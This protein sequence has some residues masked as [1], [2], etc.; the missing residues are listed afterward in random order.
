MRKLALLALTLTA[1]ASS[2]RAQGGLSPA[3]IDAFALKSAGRYT[4]A[5][6]AFLDLAEREVDD[7]TALTAARAVVHVAVARLLAERIGAVDV[8]A[9]LEALA[10]RSGQ[11]AT[12][13]ALR[14]AAMRLCAGAGD[15][16]A[17]V[18]AQRALGYLTRFWTC[19][20]F[21]NER[22]QGFAQAYP[23]ETGFDVAGSYDGKKRPVAW[24]ALPVT[25]PPEGIVDLGAL[26]RPD[27]Q[28]LV[29]A[30]TALVAERDDDAMLLLGTDGSYRV[31]LN[32]E[33]VAARDVRRVRRADQD[34]VALRLRRGPNLLLLKLCAQDGPLRFSARLR[35]ARGQPIPQ[36]AE[37]D[38][39]SDLAAAA[40][41]AAAERPAPKLARRAVEV[42]TES[43]RGGDAAD[44]FR[45][46]TLLALRQPDDPNDRRDR[47]LAEAAVAA[48]PDFTPAR[49]L[50]A[51][52]R[53]QTGRAEEKD[54]NQRR[55]DYEEILARDPRHAEAMRSLAEMDLEDVGAA[56]RAEALCRRALEV[57][58]EFAAARLLLARAL[59]AQDL[60][61][62]ADDEVLAAAEPGAEGRR[63]PEAMR[64]ALEV[65][66]RT[67]DPRRAEALARGLV[68]TDVD[69]A[70][71]EELARALL[72][73]G[74]REEALSLLRR[75]EAMF[76]FDPRPR[77]LLARAMEA[78]SDREGAA[79]VLLGWLDVCPEDD[80]VLV[81]LARLAGLLGETE[82]E[83]ELLRAA[84]DLNPN[85]KSEVRLLEFLEADEVPFHQAYERDADATIA[86]VGAPPADAEAANDSHHWILRQEV[87]RA[88]RNGTRSVY[89]HEIV[90]VLS[91]RAIRRFST[92][93]V[94]HDYREERARILSARV[95]KPDGRELRPRLRGP[96]AQLPP[97]EVGDIVDVRARIDD[98]APTIFGDYFGLVHP[99]V[100]RD[101][102][103]VA[104]SELVL[105]LDPGRDYEYQQANGA[106][107]PES[108]TEDSGVLVR[109]WV[110]RDLA[111]ADA[112]ERAPGWKETAPLVRVTTYRSWDAFAAWW[113]NL[114]RRQSDVSPEMRQ[115]VEQL[116][117][118]AGTDAEKIAAIYAFVT[119]EVRY[120][121]WEF[122]V[123]GYK[124]YNTSV[125]FERRHGD[126]K[127]KSLLLNA[128]LGIAGIEAWPVLI[129]AERARDTDDLS[130]AMVEH[131]NHCI[132]FVPAHGDRP[133]MFLDGTA[134]WHTTDTIPE[135]DQGA[136]V[137]VVRGP[138]GEL[139]DVPWVDATLNV[140]D[141]T[142]RV[143]LDPDGS[144][145]A[146]LV[147]T[148]GRN[149]AVPFREFLANEPARREENVERLLSRSFGGVKV[150]ELDAGQPED[151]TR[152]V[153]LDV[154]FEGEDLAA[155]QGAGLALKPVFDTSPL[156][157]FTPAATRERPLLLG[158]PES[159][160]RIVRY[161]LPDGWAPT[162][163]PAPVELDARF[164]RYALRWSFDDG[165]L[166]VERTRSIALPRIEAAEYPDFREFAG[167]ADAADARTVVVRPE[168]R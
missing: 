57:S 108:T 53:V 56:A 163:L 150:D 54:E 51:F 11:P 95:V 18:E 5:L 129:W 71:I 48:M 100:A 121:A 120:K 19:G 22:G 99:F 29:Y 81:E 139:R 9:R 82:R 34:V 117:A 88:Y 15:L 69:A 2:A 60:Q 113:W 162:D 166:T 3:E 12:R 62:L 89:R 143:A 16:P 92:W 148:P 33:E 122:G 160:H 79:A 21:D 98:V 47:G 142:I 66:R 46:A 105:L 44:A 67:P 59:A 36:V 76:P 8:R 31:F 17:V 38:D 39:P 152:P 35:D 40:R 104:I 37:S 91:D 138:S 145:R 61:A 26:V 58:P 144:G 125:I 149:Q 110:M 135:M 155:R 50:L 64:A 42:L 161:Q 77:R 146:T 115:K 65:A 147:A 32:G 94:P 74:A 27:E 156:Q 106:P 136:R 14:H 49:Y 30:A 20:P 157:R 131:F 127:D 28:V 158:V 134:T 154:G 114:V 107:D 78:A 41:T 151:L 1:T 43:A 137:L 85:R 7:G 55:F 75:G 112:E 167:R 83:R 126:C 141:R 168:G 6:D 52:T 159:E 109:H 13:D 24:R 72:R 124:P 93:V 10:S 80:D 86:A 119:N 116:V 133:A 70:A 153:R 63:S 164:G 128:M 102:Q 4:E 45:V 130:L 111:R 101:G 25:E 97:L 118:G 140:D 84:I 68:R 90:R 123:H 96:V 103:P 165:V 87:V 132:S 73:R 23:P